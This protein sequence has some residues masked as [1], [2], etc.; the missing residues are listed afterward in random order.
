VEKEKLNNHEV[1]YALGLAALAAGAEV[2]EETA[3]L[4]IYVTPFAVQRVTPPVAWAVLEALRPLGEKAPHR[5]GS[6]L[7]AVSELAALG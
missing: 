2:D 7:A 5:Y 6:L 3:G 4:L 1:F